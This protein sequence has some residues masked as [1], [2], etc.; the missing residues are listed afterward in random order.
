MSGNAKQVFHGIT[1]AIFAR[2]RKKASQLG[3]RVVEPRGEVEKDGVVIQWSYD[4]SAQVLEVETK[5]PFWINA[6]QV[7]RTLRREIESSRAA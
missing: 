7:N 4:A 5:A 2:L 1:R 3:M 6:S